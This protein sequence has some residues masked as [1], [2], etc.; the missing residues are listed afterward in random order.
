[1]K[2]CLGFI[3]IRFHK[4]NKK[5]RLSFDPIPFEGIK[6]IENLI[7]TYS[8]F[9]KVVDW[10]YHLSKKSKYKYYIKQLFNCI[11]LS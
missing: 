6:I 5:N 9:M 1:M 8:D 7:K 4:I 10:A 2:E 11:F 3:K